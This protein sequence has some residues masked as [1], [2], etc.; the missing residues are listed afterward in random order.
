MAR[1][2][3]RNIDDGM[4]SIIIGILDGWSNKLSWELLIEAV[5]SRVGHRYTRQAL[6]ANGNIV[7]AYRTHRDRLRGTFV[8]APSAEEVSPETRILLDSIERLE[9]ENARLLVENRGYCETFTRWVANASARGLTEEYLNIPLPKVDREQTG[10][11][12]LR[13]VKG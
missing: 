4:T 1:I 10:G 8:K 12:K 2:R 9:A 3:G 6:A 5:F 11:M 7:V 13:K